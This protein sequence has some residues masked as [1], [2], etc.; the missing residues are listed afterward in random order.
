MDQILMALALSEGDEEVGEGKK[1]LA[2]SSR[3]KSSGKFLGW[4]SRKCNYVLT[5]IT[6]VKP[7]SLGLNLLI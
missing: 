3:T 1:C 7:Q 4:L 6:S 5:G 2:S